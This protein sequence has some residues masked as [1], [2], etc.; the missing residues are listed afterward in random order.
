MKKI[1]II[2]LIAVY[3]L[4]FAQ[5]NPSKSEKDF[6]D[7]LQYRSFL[8]FINE[9]NP[10]IGLVKDRNTDESACSIAAVGWA[11]PVW[12]IGAENH[13]ITREKASG[14]TLNLIRFLC[15]S[16]QSTEP[17]ATGYKGFYYHFLNM[18]TGK[19]EWNSELS[20]I[21]T[22]WLLAGI[23]FAMQYYDLDNAAE[24][25]IRE[26]GDRLTNRVDWNWTIIKKSK[27]EGHQ[28]LIAMSYKPEE[29]LGD[30]G[31]YGYTEALYLY[32]LAAG[33]NL[34]NPMEVYNVW[35]S[36]YVWKEPYPGLGHIIFPPLFGHQY[37]EMFIDFRGLADKYLKEKGIDYFENSRRATLSNRNYCIQN[38]QGWTGYDSLTWGISACDGPGDFEKDGK[39]FYG[40]GGRGASGPDDNY[41][42]DGTLTPEAAGGSIPFAPEVCIPT[43]LNMYEKYGDKGLWG[44]Y[45]LKDAFNLTVD[46]YDKDYLGLD[47]GPIVIMIEN[48]KSGLIWKYSMKDTVIIKGLEKLGFENVE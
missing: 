15:N 25:A 44:I 18:N 38:L 17:D 13:W 24:K 20:T 36:G 43:L 34:N 2:F 12:A 45:G 42:D 4:S 39:R 6:L 31:W 8:Y 21:D 47:E 29:G 40:Y 11:V 5:Y 10:E 48:Y 19:R 28:G 27:H 3:Q 16:E 26:L 14:L 32:I 1:I 9:I 41:I 23:R 33:T 30:F 35:L 46:W 7:S 22:A 37:S